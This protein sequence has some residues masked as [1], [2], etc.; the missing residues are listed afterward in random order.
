MPACGANGADCRC[1]VP[2]ADT[3]CSSVLRTSAGSGTGE[4]AEYAPPMLPRPA[5]GAAAPSP[6]AWGGQ[7]SF[8]RRAAGLRGDAE[9]ALRRR[10]VVAP[11][12]VTPLGGC[13]WGG[14]GGGGVCGVLERG[15]TAGMSAAAS[16]ALCAALRCG[17]TG[18]EM[19]S[20]PADEASVALS[21]T[22]AG[23]A[24]DRGQ[25]VF[26]T[27][28]TLRAGEKKQRMIAM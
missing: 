15:V 2:A 28:L 9:A 3:R 11:E 10:R 17:I 22:C 26:R 20:S 27:V 5:G 18:T 16:P 21:A 25:A 12:R 14:A 13:S 8:A 24:V 23:R 6:V 4:A 7:L 19:L 1:S